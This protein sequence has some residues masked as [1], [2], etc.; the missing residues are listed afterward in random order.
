MPFKTPKRLR[1]FVAAL[2]WCGCLT[3]FAFAM[4]GLLFELVP[5]GHAYHILSQG[6]WIVVGIAMAVG[7]VSAVLERPNASS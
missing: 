2:K 1:K 4:V 6:I 5:L 3:A 7:F